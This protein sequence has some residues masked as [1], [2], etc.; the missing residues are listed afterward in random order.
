MTDFG[1]KRSFR[2]IG[3]CTAFPKHS[4]RPLPPSNSVADSPCAGDMGSA[5]LPWSDCLDLLVVHSPSTLNSLTLRGGGN[6]AA[7][8]ALPFMI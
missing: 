6:L 8:T 3:S 1:R 4:A 7:F 5:G 2:F